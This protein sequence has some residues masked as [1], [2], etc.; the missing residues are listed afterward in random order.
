[1][2]VCMTIY[3]V[4]WQKSAQHCKAVILQLKKKEHFERKKKKKNTGMKI[5]WKIN[6]DLN[7]KKKK[8]N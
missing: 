7:V 4:V 8:S 1:M 2:C 6:E 5:T 3:I